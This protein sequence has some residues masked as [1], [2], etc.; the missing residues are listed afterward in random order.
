MT[1]IVYHPCQSKQWP[2]PTVY[3]VTLQP[4]PDCVPNPAPPTR[5]D[6][7]GGQQFYIVTLQPQGDCVPTS[8]LE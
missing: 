4:L 6:K 7:D 8:P 1:V 2:W 5:V 3:N